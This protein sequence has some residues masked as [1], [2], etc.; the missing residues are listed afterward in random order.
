[1]AKVVYQYPKDIKTTTSKL[2]GD[3][4]S[5]GKITDYLVIYVLDTSK[6]QGGFNPFQN[7]GTPNAKTFSGE[8]KIV[9]EIYLHMPNQIQA[10]YQVTYNDK[11][12]GA[13]GASA[14]GAISSGNAIS[15]EQIQMAAKSMAPE[16]ASNALA[17]ALGAANSITGVGGDSLSGSDLSVLTQRKAFNPY[18]ENVFQ[19]VP[20]RQHSFNI[21]MVPRNKEEAE[22]IKGI[23]YLMKYAMHP[24]FSGGE[25]VFGIG[26]GGS[27]SGI[28]STRWLDLPY[29]FGL[30]YK[31]LG[32]TTKE[33]LYKFKPT[34][35]TA[36]N[37][38]YT[39]DGNYVTGRDLTD[40][41]DHGLACNLQM[42]FKE[43]Q[44]VTKG[45]I[46]QTAGV[47]Y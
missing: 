40:F 12:L 8:G 6:S 3:A 36:L 46:G 38:D 35:L 43:T 23:V 26:G 41:N 44:I 37:V 10:N 15:A 27:T 1:M 16:I 31:R 9:G 21:K 22:Q 47:T 25:G 42:T 30:E 2:P 20:F 14:V 28:A 24:S 32:T 11:N 45:D 7:F 39:P 33:L 18:K 17:T 13:I 19:G 5:K 4:M 34:V 29:S